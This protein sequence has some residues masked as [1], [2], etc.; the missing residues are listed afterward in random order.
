M[1]SRST[2]H[3]PIENQIIIKSSVDHYQ[4]SI[5]EGKLMKRPLRQESPKN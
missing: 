4:D 1:L 2:D 5:Q 3:I